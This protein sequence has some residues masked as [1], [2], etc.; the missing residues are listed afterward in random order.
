MTIPHLRADVSRED[1]VAAVE[2]AGATVIGSRCVARTYGSGRSRTAPLDRKNLDWQVSI[3]GR[4]QTA[5]RRIGGSDR[6][7]PDAAL[8]TT[9]FNGLSARRLR[10]RLR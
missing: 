4:A 2:A 10:P 8:G 3:R 5:H 6:D 1:V 7:C 9:T